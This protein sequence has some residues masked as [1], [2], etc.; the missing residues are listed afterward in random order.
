M[1]S[2]GRLIVPP[3]RRQANA[4]AAA[5][6]A[7]RAMPQYDGFLLSLRQRW[8]AIRLP[9]ATALFTPLGILERIQC[10]PHDAGLQTDS[11]LRP[12]N[13]LR[14][15]LH[16]LDEIVA[17]HFHL[18]DT[19]APAWWVRE[20]LHRDVLKD[21]PCSW[22]DR[23]DLWRF[24]APAPAPEL[25]ITTEGFGVRVAQHDPT[26]AELVSTR[27]FPDRESAQKFVDDT[28]ARHEQAQGWQRNPV[29]ETK[30]LEHDIPALMH[31][32]RS[33][34][35]P[36]EAAMR[37]RLTQIARDVLML[38]PPLADAVASP[39]S[40]GTPAKVRRKTSGRFF[41]RLAENAE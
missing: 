5:M 27:V 8:S 28:Y 14:L 39:E 32:Y 36:S 40:R 26:T 35:G 12:S 3:Q 17:Q 22:T 19:G 41:V 13:A 23:V 16:K 25:R 18:T 20:D 9:P 4:R 30:M 37:R 38:D 10:G 24:E 34:V 6:T 15:Y 1:A 2:T 11:G 31:W 33:G 7:L 29:S 21:D